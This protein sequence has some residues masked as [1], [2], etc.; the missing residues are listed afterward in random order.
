VKLPALLIEVNSWLPFR[1]RFIHPNADVRQPASGRDDLLDMCIFAVILA[2]GCNLPLTTMAEASGLSYH[3]LVHTADWYMR[4]ATIRQA[5]IALVDYH[6]SLPLAATFGPGA[7]AMS[8]GIRFGVTARS[9]Y[10]RNNPRLPTRT[11]RVS[12]YDMT[13]DQGSQP[14]AHTGIQGLGRIFKTIAALNYISDEDYRRRIHLP[15]CHRWPLQSRRDPR[16]LRHRR[17]RPCTSGH[18]RR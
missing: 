14:G 8:D 5:I 7:S 16:L 17:S 3:K 13:N 11:R 12:V 2:Q 10:A 4:E 1:Q 6:H 9:L 15:V 18:N